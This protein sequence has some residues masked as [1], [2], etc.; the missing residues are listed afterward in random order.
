M[1]GTEMKFALQRR[2]IGKVKENC[3]LKSILCIRKPEI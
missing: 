3:I 2:E 1:F